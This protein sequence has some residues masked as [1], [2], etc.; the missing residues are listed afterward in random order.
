MP[1]NFRD[2]CTKIICVGRNYV[3]HAK[4]LGNDPPS[5]PIIFLKPP[6][7]L[8]KPDDNI[9]IPYKCN[10]FHH[11]LELGVIIGENSNGNVIAKDKAM[12]YVSGYCLSLDMTARDIQQELKKKSLPWTISKGFDG[13]APVSYF[14]DKKLIKNYKNIKMK[15]TINNNDIRQETTCDLMIFDIETLINYLS[16]YF[17]LCKGDIILTGT[18]KGVGQVVEGDILTSE[19]WSGNGDFYIRMQNKIVANSKL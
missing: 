3:A 17:T 14:I 15:L 4:E 6:S 9:R 1:A 13:A 18:P 11:E 5:T 19:L 12:D 10:N 2:L 8:I 16:K 7:S